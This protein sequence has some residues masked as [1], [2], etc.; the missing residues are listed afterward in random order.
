MSKLLIF[1]P[2]IEDGGVEKNLFLISEYLIEKG[3]DVSLITAN[4]DKKKY[5]RKIL[6]V[7]KNIFSF[8]YLH[9]KILIRYRSTVHTVSSPS[10]SHT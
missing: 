8:A 10:R 3:I 9:Y 2:S 7:K 6:I 5:D 1:I 4:Q